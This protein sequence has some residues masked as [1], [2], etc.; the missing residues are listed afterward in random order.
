MHIPSFS[1]SN[2]VTLRQLSSF[3]SSYAPLTRMVLVLSSSSPRPLEYGDLTLWGFLLKNVNKSVSYLFIYFSCVS[4]HEVIGF[5]FLFFFYIFDK[6]I[7]TYLK[8]FFNYKIFMIL[9]IKY[10][11]NYFS[12]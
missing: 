8:F 2:I 6:W 3:S 11:T 4:R 9:L 5:F 10:K 12:L 7:A 1:T